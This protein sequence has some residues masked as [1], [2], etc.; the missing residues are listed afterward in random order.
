ME[1]IHVTDH[2]S[3][4]NINGELIPT[5]QRKSD[6]PPGGRIKINNNYY[7]VISTGNRLCCDN[8]SFLNGQYCNVFGLPCAAHEREDNKNVIFQ[9]IIERKEREFNGLLTTEDLK[10]K[11]GYRW[12]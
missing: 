4:F 1:E 5:N 6:T 3:F 12:K 2:D 10:A 11:L 8:C 9:L 7:T